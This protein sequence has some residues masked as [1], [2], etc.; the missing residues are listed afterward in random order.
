VGDKPYK[1]AV[2]LGGQEHFYSNMINSL[3]IFQFL[4]HSPLGLKVLH[5]TTPRSTVLQKS[6]NGLALLLWLE[7]P[8]S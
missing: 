1:M 6:C 2:R 5:K 3:K 7:L 8:G 4:K